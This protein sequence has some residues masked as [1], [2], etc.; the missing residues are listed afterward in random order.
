[1]NYIA[2]GRVIRSVRLPVEQVFRPVRLSVEQVFRPVRLSVV[3]A[4]L[5]SAGLL[6]QSPP[7]GQAQPP[8]TPPPASTATQI[9]QPPTYKSGIDMV[10]TDVIVRDGRGQFVA[11]LKPTD[12]EVLED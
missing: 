1:M 4:L 2:E 12:F 8:K 3:A 11:D 7:A 10:T 9:V 5:L 6:A